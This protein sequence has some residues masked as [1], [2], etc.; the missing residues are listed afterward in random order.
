VEDHFPEGGLGEAVAASLSPDGIRVH[1]MAVNEI[2]R[3]GKPEELLAKYGIDAAAI[4]KK[5][6]S[7]VS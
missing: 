7:L 5:V 3:S 1:R 4:V 6:G 2:P